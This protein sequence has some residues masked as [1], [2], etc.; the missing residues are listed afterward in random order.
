MDDDNLLTQGLLAWRHGGRMGFGLW[1]LDLDDEEF[2]TFKELLRKE[3]VEF[4]VLLYEILERIFLL[5]K[6]KLELELDISVEDLLEV[7]DELV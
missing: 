1:L 5:W 4:S 7:W 6:M 3:L 2:E